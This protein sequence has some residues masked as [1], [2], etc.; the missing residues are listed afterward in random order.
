MG[1]DTSYHP[2]DLRFVQ[3]PSAESR[4]DGRIRR[5]NLE[6]HPSPNRLLDSLVHHPHPAATEHSQDL[7]IAEPGV[8]VEERGGGHGRRVGADLTARTVERCNFIQEWAEIS[9]EVRVCREIRGPVRP[10]TPFECGQKL[11]HRPVNS[12]VPIRYFRFH[13]PLQ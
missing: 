7:E 10:I 5:Q 9:R 6:C 3:E 4:V 13:H 12:V 11:G 2:L 8:P 1:F